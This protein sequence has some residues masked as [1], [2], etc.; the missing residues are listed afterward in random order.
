MSKIDQL[1]EEIAKDYLGEMSQ[2]DALGMAAEDVIV[3]LKE[4]YFPCYY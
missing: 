4:K 2:K 1:I 3:Y